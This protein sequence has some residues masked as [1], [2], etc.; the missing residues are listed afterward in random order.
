MSKQSTANKQYTTNKQFTV[1]L[2]SVF[3]ANMILLGIGAVIGNVTFLNMSVGGLFAV[4]CVRLL[5]SQKVPGSDDH[6]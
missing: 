2:N 5:A 3:V 1:S 4:F 6:D